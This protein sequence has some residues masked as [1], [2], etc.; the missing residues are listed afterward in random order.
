MKS[1]N[2]IGPSRAMRSRSRS[3]SDDKVSHYS[4]ADAVEAFGTRAPRG[5]RP[6]R[7]FVRVASRR[8]PSH[9]RRLFRRHVA[10]RGDAPAAVEVGRD[11]AGP[12]F[13]RL[14]LGGPASARGDRRRRDAPSPFARGLP[15]LAGSRSRGRSGRGRSAPRHGAG[16]HPRPLRVTRPNRGDAL[17]LSA[18]RKAARDPARALPVGPRSRRRAPAG[19]RQGPSR[20]GARRGRRLADGVRLARELALRLGG[21]A[22]LRGGRREGGPDPAPSRVPPRRDAQRAHSGGAPAAR[23]RGPRLRRRRAARPLRPGRGRQPPLSQPRRRHLRGRGA[24][25]GR[26]GAGGRGRR[27][28]LVR[29]R[30]RR[31]ARSLRDLPLRPQPSVPQSGRRHVRGGRREGGSRAERRLD[32]GRGARL[33]PRRVAR[34]LRPRLRA[35][36][37][38]PQFLG[39]QRASQP[40]LPQQRRRDLLRRHGGVA[41]R[42]HGLGPRAPIRRPRRRRL[43]RP[44][45]RQ[46][47]RQPCLP[48]QRGRRHVPQRRGR[49]RSARSG[50]RDGRRGRRRRRRR[51]ARPLR[52]ELFVPAQVVPARPPLSDAA[53]PVLDRPS[54]G[55]AAAHGALARF[56]PL[57]QPRRRSESLRAH[58]R[59]GRHLGHLVV[60][61]L[62]LR[63]RRPGRDARTSSWSTGC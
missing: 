33:R 45:H 39:R 20:A 8:A 60:V 3:E 50:L 11:L 16:G 63:G 51:A 12:L 55:L 1:T 32:L 41:D 47:L 44:L 6:P 27:R 62:R 59:R 10:V 61:G 46:R 7:S 36:R 53:L 18:R 13:S 57:P 56:F 38:G 29:L 42:R 9:A 26:R 23:G 35:P 54:P 17:R 30:Q 21:L 43:A 2:E 4:F 52:V 25:S 22:A 28:A 37:L 49:G 31:A 19:G 40:P 14:P 34:S 5:G 24:A 15:G 48:P 58:L